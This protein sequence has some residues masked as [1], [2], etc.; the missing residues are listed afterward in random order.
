MAKAKKKKAMKAFS[1]TI[2]FGILGFR[3]KLSFRR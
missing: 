1:I 2:E 3:F